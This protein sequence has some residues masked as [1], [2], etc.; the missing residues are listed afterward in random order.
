MNAT[1]WPALCGPALS[2]PHPADLL[3]L[4]L[5]APLLEEWIVRAGLQAWLLQRP[6]FAASYAAAPA[7]SAAAFSVL[8]LGAGWQA[9]ALV[10]GPGLALGLVYQRWR[11]WRLCAVLHALFN[12]AAVSV[13][14]SPFFLST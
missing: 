12:A 1:I 14:T 9:A 10:F 3:R 6:A 7:L 8:H 2:H 5:L 4:L 13:C 11:D